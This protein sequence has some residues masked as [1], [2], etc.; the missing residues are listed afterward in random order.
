M[1]KRRSRQIA[2]TGQNPMH[3]VRQRFF[4]PISEI[5]EQSV[6]PHPVVSP[7]ENSKRVRLSLFAYARTAAFEEERSWV[8]KDNGISGIRKQDT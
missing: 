3:P 2:G 8:K 6:K 5:N 7:A 4:D 1:L